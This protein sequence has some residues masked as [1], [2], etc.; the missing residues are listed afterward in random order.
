MILKKF[1]HNR[2]IICYIEQ[3]KNTYSVKTGKPSD[4]SCLSWRYDNLKDAE[5]TASEYFE[6]Y[7]N[8]KTL[9]YI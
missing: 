9:M 3:Y 7:T 8:K 6:N 2:K 4:D 5:K 1:K